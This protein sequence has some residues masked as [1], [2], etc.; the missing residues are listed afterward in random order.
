M[1]GG[2]GKV[3]RLYQEH[4]LKARGIIDFVTHWNLTWRD[5]QQELLRQLRTEPARVLWLDPLGAS[6]ATGSA[7][8][9]E[10][11]RIV[12]ELERTQV[13]LGLSAT[14]TSPHPIPS[15][16]THPHPNQPYPT[17]PHLTTTRNP[18]QTKPN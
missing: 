3:S 13:D 4:N 12:G 8:D 2:S 15:N 6:T 1:L 5:Y 11:G 7:K 18:T 14:P 16:T 10:L 17:L 9:L